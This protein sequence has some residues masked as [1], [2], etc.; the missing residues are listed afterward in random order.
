MIVLFF[1]KQQKRYEEIGQ[2]YTAKLMGL[3]AAY[4]ERASGSNG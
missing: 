3:M 4:F 1:R 2:P